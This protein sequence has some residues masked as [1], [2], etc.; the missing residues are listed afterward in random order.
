MKSRHQIVASLIF[1]NSRTGL[2]ELTKRKGQICTKLIQNFSNE[3]DRILPS[4]FGEK[5]NFAFFECF[6]QDGLCK[7]IFKFF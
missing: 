4:N 2:K 5:K 1:P 7:N 3:K 6:F